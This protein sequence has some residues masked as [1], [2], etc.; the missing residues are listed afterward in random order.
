[1]EDGRVGGR[2][3]GSP[4]HRADDDGREGW[5]RRAKSKLLVGLSF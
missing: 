2:D 5:P 3:R 4:P 1:M